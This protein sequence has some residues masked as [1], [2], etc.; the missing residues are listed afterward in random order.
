M[1]GGESEV[2]PGT[3]SVL[4]ESACFLPGSVRRTSRTLGLST[5]AAYRFER[6]TDIEGVVTALD[7]AA[8]LMADL[9]GGTVG[10]GR[11]DVY[12]VPHP[13][14]RIALR[15]SR[16]ERV[17]G[18]APPRAEMVRILRSLGFPVADSGPTLQVDV[19]SFRRDVVQEDDLVEEIAR[20]WGYD[21]IPVTLAP[22][23]TLL[24]VRRPATLSLARTV[25]RALNAAGL[26]ECLTYSFLDPER[27]AVM[28]WRDPAG[29]LA[30][31][32]PLSQERSVL[33]PS[34]VPGLLEVLETN[35][36]R[37]TPDVAV[38]EV[39]H[40][41]SPHRDE[42]GD[43]PAH[44][45]LWV[46]L[47][48]TGLRAGRA[49]HAPRD[50]ADVHD[51][52]GMVELALS[53]VGVS[54]AEVIPWAA[55]ETP[56]YL[57]EERGARLVVSGQ[58]VGW[59]GEVTKA[60]RERFDL[61]A[62]VVVAGVSLT[63]ISALPELVPRYQPLPRFPAVQRDLAVIVRAGVPAEEIEAA[64]RSLE[65]PWLTR[66]ALFDVYE[67][68]QVGAG[69]R[70]LAWSLTFQAED[71]TLTDAEVNEVH[72]RIVKEITRRFDAEVRGT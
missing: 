66:V 36:H 72:A 60:V 47:A 20:V 15:P 3:T 68:S 34:L 1:G 69:R 43:R 70:S 48:L 21:K 59:F 53:A 32:N 11:I 56:G 2:T 7:R 5:D 14:A 30:L 46:G 55:G 8:Q 29:L 71:R 10:R 22:G 42:D 26:S 38:F 57:E 52:K 45:E 41:F 24:P 67:G 4:L 50:R 39:G 28:G 49:W 64:I 19:P 12:P 40:V 25:G 35:I 9:G 51:A 44:E 23:G 58:E 13:Q 18:A 33:R 31:Q 63:A 16:V 61:H 54:G 65:V 27:L 37:Q 17:I 6:G 62:P